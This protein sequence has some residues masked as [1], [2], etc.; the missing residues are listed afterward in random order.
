MRE[1]FRRRAHALLGVGLEGSSA[2]TQPPCLIQ[3]GISVTTAAHDWDLDFDLG[4]RRKRNKFSQVLYVTA[5][6]VMRDT[7]QL[8]IQSFMAIFG[9]LPIPERPRWQQRL[10]HQ[11]RRLS[12]TLPRTGAFDLAVEND[13]LE[14][15]EDES[16]DQI[17]QLPISSE[18]PNRIY[19][20]RNNSWK[21]ERTQY[22]DEMV[23]YQKKVNGVGKAKREILR[24]AAASELRIATTGSRLIDARVFLITLKK[25]LSPRT[26]D[27]QYEIRLK[28]ENLRRTPKRNLKE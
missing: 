14:F 13:I 26:A 1:E 9:Y 12:W 23:K 22:S 8:D 10:A 5:R 7:I 17:D 18:Y 20:R 21:I 4:I 6:T 25:I 16:S 28:Y 3:A 2:W 27:C 19:P 11:N 15:I 24:T